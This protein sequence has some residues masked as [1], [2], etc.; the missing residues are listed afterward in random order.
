MQRTS[1]QEEREFVSREMDDDDADDDDCQLRWR[2]IEPVQPANSALIVRLLDHK[3][4][5]T[6]LAFSCESL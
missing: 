1:Y 4:K 6:N 5:A 2:S 3:R